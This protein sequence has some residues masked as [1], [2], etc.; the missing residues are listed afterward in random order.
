MAAIAAANAYRASLNHRHHRV[1]GAP[2][3]L[4]RFGATIATCPRSVALARSW[5]SATV[6]AL[7]ASAVL[8]PVAPL[9]GQP[10]L[11]P[12]ITAARTSE[13]TIVVAKT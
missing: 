8:P 1:W 2:P 10:P 11:A 5:W 13:E 6:A 12:R 9:G 4:I 7:P 3:P